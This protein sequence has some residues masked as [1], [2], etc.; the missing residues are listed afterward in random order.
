M[1]LT[2]KQIIL[3][4][5]LFGLVSCGE[6]PTSELTEQFPL[7]RSGPHDMEFAFIPRSTFRMGS[8]EDEEGRDDDEHWHWVKLTEDS[9]M[10]TTEVTRGQWYKVMNSYPDNNG[11]CWEGD[12]VIK[13]NNHPVVCVSWDEV[14]EFV[15]KLNDKER[16]SGYRYSLPTEAQWEYAARAY[17]ETPYSIK[18]QLKSFAW[19]DSLS[20]DH[21]HPVGELKPNLF[22]LHDV[23]GNVW[24]WVSDWYG[25]YPKADDL[26]DAVINPIGPSSGDYRVLR[27]G[28]WFND[29]RFCRSARRF[30]IRPDYRS[31][32]VGFRLMR[33]KI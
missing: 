30:T 14:K 10:Q 24:E 8:S 21:A 15:D 26:S 17:T 19:Y 29:A 5:M 33:I 32:V 28:S 12:R 20:G 7:I 1:N 23:H 16:S 2:P 31:N 22:G 9:W 13:E 6:T 4:I 25:K 11:K 27:G 18:G 3:S